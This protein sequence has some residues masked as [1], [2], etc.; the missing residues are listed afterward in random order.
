M[1]YSGS[2]FRALI[3]FEINGL[4]RRCEW[5]RDE[6]DNAYWRGQRDALAWALRI[7]RSCYYEDSPKKD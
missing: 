3:T 5:E 4:E 7:H 1:G 6:L 2:K